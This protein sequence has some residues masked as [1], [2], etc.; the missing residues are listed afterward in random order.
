MPFVFK[1]NAASNG[2]RHERSSFEY[3]HTYIYT[4]RTY[5]R[6]RVDL[7]AKGG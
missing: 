7:K 1:K 4:Y 6:M 5:K 3:I 2:R